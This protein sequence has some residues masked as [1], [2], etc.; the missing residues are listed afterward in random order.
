MCFRAMARGRAKRK[1]G[2]CDSGL[3][4]TPTCCCDFAL[5]A[6]H[7]AVIWRGFHVPHQLPVLC[8]VVSCWYTVV[9]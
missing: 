1:G 7:H 6:F 8:F 5:G 4:E 9:G 3:G 2:P